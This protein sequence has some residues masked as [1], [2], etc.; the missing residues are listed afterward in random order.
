MQAKI[1][2]KEIRQRCIRWTLQT[3]QMVTI[4]GLRTY[5]AHPDMYW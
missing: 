4:H 2:L 1:Q 3:R 5:I